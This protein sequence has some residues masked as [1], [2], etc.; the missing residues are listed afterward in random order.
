LKINLLSAANAK[1][2]AQK[3]FTPLVKFISTFAIIVKQSGIL[4]L[5]KNLQMNKNNKKLL[6]SFK[7]VFCERCDKPA[8]RQFTKIDFNSTYIFYHC[9]ICANNF[10]VLQMADINKAETYDYN[11]NQYYNIDSLFE[12]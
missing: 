11:K 6:D 10:I 9:T 5:Q 4:E 3:N 1:D 7:I 12:H 8:I 2:N